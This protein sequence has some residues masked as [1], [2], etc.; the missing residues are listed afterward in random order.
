MTEYVEDP[1]DKMRAMVV[2]DWATEKAGLVEQY[3]DASRAARRQYIHR[4]YI[5]LFC[6]PGRVWMRDAKR[7]ED[8]CALGAWKKSQEK[9]V[10]FSRVY[11]ADIDQHNVQCCA[12]ASKHVVRPLCR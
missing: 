10:P 9:N 7:F 3:I 8:G 2:G 6:G 11:I 12:N 1:A 4:A 5:D